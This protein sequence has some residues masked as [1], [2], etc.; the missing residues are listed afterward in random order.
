MPNCR[1]TKTR[2]AESVKQR[3]AREAEELC[4][5]GEVAADELVR[6]SRLNAENFGKPYWPKCYSI[7]A[8]FEKR[9]KMLDQV[10]KAKNDKR[11][12]VLL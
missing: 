4:R 7:K 3:W 9:V 1:P 11:E 10:E 8:L 6:L 12:E 5:K 2:S